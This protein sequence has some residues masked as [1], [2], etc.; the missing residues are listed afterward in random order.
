[1]HR[2]VV[3]IGLALIAVLGL[4]SCSQ[5]KIYAGDKKSGVFFT[6]QN[7]WRMVSQKELHD[8]QATS[9]NSVTQS[10]L[11]AVSY[12]TAFSPDQITASD[13]LSL[14]SPDSVIAYARVRGLSGD[15]MN[16]VS[17]NWLRDLVFPVT[18][19]INSPASAPGFELFN[20]LEVVQPGARGIES[21]FKVTGSDGI[22]QTIDQTALVSNDHSSIYIFLIRAKSS[23]YEKNMNVISKLA[24]SFTVKGI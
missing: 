2:K 23:Y 24:H 3:A 1:M 10:R 9:K 7:G 15:E 18:T 20:D 21:I 16:A 17:Y 8:L 4:T 12:E 5:S 19:W 6:V 11:Q 13:V 22:S 14:S